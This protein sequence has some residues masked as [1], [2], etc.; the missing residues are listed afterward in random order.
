MD[1]WPDDVD[2]VV[3]ARAPAPGFRL[4]DMIREWRGAA[5]HLEKRVREAREDFKNRC[6]LPADSP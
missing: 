3:V 2:V 1:L 5:R 4:A 6:N